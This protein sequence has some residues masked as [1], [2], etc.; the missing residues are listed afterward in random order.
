[1]ATQHQQWIPIDEVITA[2]M[3]EA[4]ISNH[5]YFKLWHICFD[6]MTELGLDAFYTIQ[7][8]KLPVLANLTVPLPANCLQVGKVGVFNEQGCVISLSNNNNLSTAFDLQPT[9][10]TQTQDNSIN[11]QLDT[12]GGIWYNYWNGSYIGNLYGLP[13]GAP[14]VGT[15]KIDNK[16]GLVV[17]GEN[18]S[19]PYIVLEYVASPLEGGEYFIPVQFKQA[20]LAYLRWRDIISI[21]SKTHVNNAN[22]GMRRR[23]YFNE[24]DLAIRRYDPIKLPELYEWNLENQRLAIKG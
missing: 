17:L 6:G 22:V 12:Q 15:Y 24:R 20:L 5:K 19:Y 23:D 9:R 8:V 14:F 10:L 1:M 18:F 2:Y 16:N 11:T 21:P 13:S 3:N 7:S 4:E